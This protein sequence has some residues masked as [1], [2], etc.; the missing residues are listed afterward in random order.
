M[1]AGRMVNSQ[2]INWRTPPKYVEAV[3]KALGGAVELAPCS[4]PNPL[5][6]QT[7]LD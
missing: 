6:L 1:T 2:S 7:R 3:K 5:S 4:N